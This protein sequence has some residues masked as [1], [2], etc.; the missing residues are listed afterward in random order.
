[1]PGKLPILNGIL[2]NT[3]D[4]NNQAVSNASATKALTLATSASAT[5]TVSTSDAFKL[6]SLTNGST[7]TLLIPSGLTM[8]AGSE[9]IFYGTSRGVIASATGSATVRTYASHDRTA[10]AYAVG[11]IVYLGS[12]E[13]LFTGNTAVA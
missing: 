13:W 11:C 4:C 3:L 7:A 6:L 8:P 9:L 2:Q 5:Y 12:D 1:M 10:G